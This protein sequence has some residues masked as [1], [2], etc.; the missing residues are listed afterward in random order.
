[1][2]PVSISGRSLK[3]CWGH[4]MQISWPSSTRAQSQL[5]KLPLLWS[6]NEVPQSHEPDTRVQD[7]SFLLIK[8]KWRSRRSVRNDANATDRRVS[9]WICQMAPVCVGSLQRWIVCATSV[10]YE[11]PT[12]LHSSRHQPPQRR[13]LLIGMLFEWRPKS[14]QCSARS[15]RSLGNALRHRHAR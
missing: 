14:R 11:R 3:L 5:C 1:M 6:N 7:A 9:P 2:A 12:T 13:H 10:T 8:P 15:V 4:A